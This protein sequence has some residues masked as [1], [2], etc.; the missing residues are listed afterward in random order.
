ME[1][2]DRQL[3]KYLKGNKKEKRKIITEYSLICSRF[4]NI[5]NTNFWSLIVYALKH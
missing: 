2:L 5:I 1:L 4:W 3:K